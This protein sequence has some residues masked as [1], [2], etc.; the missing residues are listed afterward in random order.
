MKNLLVIA[1]HFPPDNSS[2]GVLRTAKFT[3]YLLQH[4]WRSHVVTAPPSLYI[5][6]NPEDAHAGVPELTVVRAWGCDV[7][8]FFG[9]GGVYPSW[10]GIPDR[11]WPWFF[12]AR[13]AGSR[14]IRTHGIQAIYSTY[15]LPTAHLV[16]LSLKM[17]FKLPWVADFR[18][19]W[20]IEGE[21]GIAA[22]VEAFLERKVVSAADRVICNTPAMRRSFLARYPELP[23][24]RFVTITNGYD[25]TDLASISPIRGRKFQIFYPGSID[26][27]N[28][29]PRGLF[30]AVRF[31]LDRGWLDPNDLQLTFLGCGPYAD[32]DRFRSDLA[33]CALE[34]FV[35]L[36]RDRIPYKEALA[37]MAGADVV[38]VLS[39]HLSASNATDATDATE[40]WTAMQVPAKLYEYLRVGR[41]I[42]ALVGDGA[43]REL[44][45]ASGGGMPLRSHETEKIALSLRRYYEG[46]KKPMANSATIGSQIAQYSR[47]RLTDRLAKELDALVDDATPDR[48]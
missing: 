19:P 10:L 36:V 9:V 42:L 25:E 6:R 5:S 2:T 28:R 45:D 48:E 18:D 35:E 34:P 13:R 7:K 46:S 31:A 44:L 29:N 33:A 11:Y 16:G 3:E 30:L 43:V 15:P 22:K 40:R 4:Q 12:A 47:E 37:R 1:F 24:E 8:R 26:H 39:E 32:S 41:P 23:P 21:M 20:A 17:R 14:A 27:E 38:V